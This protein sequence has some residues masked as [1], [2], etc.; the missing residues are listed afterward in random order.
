M[1]ARTV[2]EQEKLLH[3]VHWKADTHSSN[4]YLKKKI[5]T[6]ILYFLLESIWGILTGFL[7]LLL[8]SSLG[9]GKAIL[10]E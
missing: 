7:L 4:L 1:G 10:V 9:K 6:S 5:F 3:C 8:V 2:T